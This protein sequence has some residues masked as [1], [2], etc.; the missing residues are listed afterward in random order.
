MDQVQGSFGTIQCVLTESSLINYTTDAT[1]SQDSDII[2]L[3]V[4][5]TSIVVLSSLKAINDLLDGR[6]AIYSDRSAAFHSLATSS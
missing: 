2:H 4:L 3:N 1:A 6:A 5:G